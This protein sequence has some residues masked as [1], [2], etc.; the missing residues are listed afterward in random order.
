[1]HLFSTPQ[2]IN[3]VYKPLSGV[4][5]SG[6]SLSTEHELETEALRFK[7]CKSLSTEHELETEAL[8]FKACKL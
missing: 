7:A 8:R 1:M 6:E 5:L 4:P 3:I 2:K